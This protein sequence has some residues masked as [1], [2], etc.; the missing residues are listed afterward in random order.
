MFIK[1]QSQSITKVWSI[2]HPMQLQHGSH[3]PAKT[4]S[5]WN[6]FRDKWQDTTVAI[7]IRKQA[8]LTY[9]T[10]TIAEF[11]STCPA[12]NSWPMHHVFRV[13]NNLINVKFSLNKPFNKAFYNPI[14]QFVRHSSFFNHHNY[15]NLEQASSLPDDAPL[16]NTDYWLHLPASL[17]IGGPCLNT[18]PIA[19]HWFP[20][21]N[22]LGYIF[23]TR[24]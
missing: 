19:Q 4:S 11:R 17:N 8:S 2:L 24:S 16:S 15:I 13:H 12:Q 21:Y 23:L 10:F 7:M 18:F 14:L 6:Q 3:T 20:L 22:L 5:H 9:P 1:C